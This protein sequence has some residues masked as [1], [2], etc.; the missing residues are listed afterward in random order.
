MRKKRRLF[1]FLSLIAVCLCLSSC[2]KRPDSLPSSD[3]EKEQR[4]FD[5]YTNE[6]FVQEL[7]E[8]TINLRY[9]LSNPESFGIHSH[10]ISL[11]NLSEE[12]SNNSLAA[13]ENIS[14][15][16]SNFNYNA[17]TT[18]QQ[19]TYD[20]LKDNCKRQ[21]A[22]ASTFIMNLSALPPERSLNFPFF[23]Q[24]TLSMMPAT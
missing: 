2:G 10:K 9:T 7:Q 21:K 5:A 4:T 23:L 1:R 3:F 12:S 13:V 14:A 8:N 19:L 15:S 11:G 20:V 17:L 22:A 16:L 18:K 24:N 6:L